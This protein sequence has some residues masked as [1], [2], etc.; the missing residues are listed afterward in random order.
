MGIAFIVANGLVCLYGWRE[1]IRICCNCLSHCVNC[2]ATTSKFL[3]KSLISLIVL[4]AIALV[5]ICMVL[6]EGIF[7]MFWT[8][9]T[10][11]D[12]PAKVF[13]FSAIFATLI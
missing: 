13:K 10:V 4:L 12:N 5:L 2:P 7:V 11:C 6:F 3:F 1:K 9:N 8:V